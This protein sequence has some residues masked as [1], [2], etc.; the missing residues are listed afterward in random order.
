MGVS[1]QQTDERGLIMSTGL[2]KYEAP[3]L[4]I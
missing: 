1:D 3:K 2:C 4:S